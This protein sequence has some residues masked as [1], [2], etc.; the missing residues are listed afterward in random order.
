MKFGSLPKQQQQQSNNSSN[1]SLKLTHVLAPSGSEAG[2]GD[3]GQY[4]GFC[5]FI[6]IRGDYAFCGLPSIAVCGQS[7]HLFYVCKY[8][9]IN[10]RRGWRSICIITT[11]LAEGESW[12]SP[13]PNVLHSPLPCSTPSPLP[14]TACVKNL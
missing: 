5:V 14:V 11:T 9:C 6:M 13:L 3:C 7:T 12:R 8:V 1:N 10:H 4:G 2:V